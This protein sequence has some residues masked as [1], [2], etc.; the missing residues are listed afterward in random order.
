M[1]KEI[2]QN[3]IRVIKT[4]KA[5]YKAFDELLQHNSLDKISVVELSKRAG[6]NKGTFY[7]HYTDIYALY[8]EAL[9]LHIDEI[10]SHFESFQYFLEDP[11][12]FAKIFVET[13]SERRKK[14]DK[15]PYLGPDNQK[16]NKGAMVYY[17][18]AISKVALLKAK[19]PE[20]DENR[21]KLQFI[22][23]GCSAMLYYQ[24]EQYKK[25]QID[26]LSKTIKQLFP[27]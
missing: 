15:D 1:K 16:W 5:I 24:D 18:E 13:S 8:Q 17:G 23:A 2:K 3:D 25:A 20:T 21:M 22:F 7:S 27:R 9:R 4:K 12:L 14:I 11:D 19:L 6:I 10:I 26:V